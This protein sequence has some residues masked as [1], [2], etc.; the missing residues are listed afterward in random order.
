VSV[1]VDGIYVAG[2]TDGRFPTQHHLG[3]DDAFVAKLGFGG[4]LLWVRQFGTRADE[5]ATA[6]AASS[7]GVFVG[8]WTRGSLQR[9]VRRGP[10][11]GFV[12]R[13]GTDGS[14]RWVRQ[15]GGKGEDEVRALAANASK[16]FAAGVTSGGLWGPSAGGSDGFLRAIGGDGHPLW[17]RQYGTFGDE[18]L[19]GVTVRG[20]ELYAAGTTTGA[21]PDQTASGGL[22]GVVLRVDQRG[23][24]LWRTQFGSPA[25]DEPSAVNLGKD[26]VYVTGSTTGALPDQT[27]AGETDAFAM[28][29]FRT[30]A[31]AWTQQFGTSDYDRAFGGALDADGVYVVGTTHGA[32]E[33]QTNAGDRDVFV[34]R[35]RFT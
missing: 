12:A 28:R 9:G 22:D 21:F 18:V 31:M 2:F 4:G 30:G 6:V 24:A 3:G 27:L 11:D 33:G 29:F 20:T 19:T 32:F 14:A 34:T 25:D 10:T 7:S 5:R 8:G 15:F 16:V 17:T 13:F 1:G 26:G 23:A 35:L